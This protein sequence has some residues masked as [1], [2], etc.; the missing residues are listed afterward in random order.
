MKIM[1]GENDGSAGIY[2]ENR[3]KTKTKTIQ[4]SY[5]LEEINLRM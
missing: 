5:L 3:K 2:C 1:K 4:N